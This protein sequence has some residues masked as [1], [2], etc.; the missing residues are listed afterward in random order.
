M[1]LVGIRTNRFELA[2]EERELR[3]EN[4]R[5]GQNRTE[6]QNTVDV[7]AGH[8]GKQE[9]DRTD[10]DHRAE[11]AVERLH[12]RQWKTRRVNANHDPESRDRDDGAVENGDE[13]FGHWKM[14]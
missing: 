4:S 7:A 14:M 6:A 1:L 3:R 11:R 5:R 13:D 10:P 2:E 9:Q 12:V 8:A